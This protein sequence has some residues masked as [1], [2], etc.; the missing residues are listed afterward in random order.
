MKDHVNV[1][2]IQNTK[3]TIGANRG[4]MWPKLEL[5]PCLHCILFLF[6]WSHFSYKC[7]RLLYFQ[8]PNM[9]ASHWLKSAVSI[10]LFAPLQFVRYWWC[11]TGSNISSDKQGMYWCQAETRKRFMCLW[12][13]I[14]CVL[15]N[16]C[17]TISFQSHK[18][19]RGAVGRTQ[20]LCPRH[21]SS[22]H[23]WN[24]LSPASF[25]NLSL[26]FLWLNLTKVK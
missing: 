16:Y 9:T 14:I 8:P 2:V 10:S 26:W 15:N 17:S 24:L 13:E 3:D 22:R 25:L 7:S 6:H 12:S 23:I 19:T 20:N 18:V 21:R 1:G 4:E 11:V 5:S